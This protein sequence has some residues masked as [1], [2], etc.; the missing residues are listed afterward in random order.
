MGNFKNSVLENKSAIITGAGGFLGPRHG[1]ALS[2]AG[3]KVVLVDI[4]E[5]GLLKA[6]EKIL[7]EN[8]EGKVE[9]YKTDITSLEAV[10][11]LEK[12]LSKDNIDISILVNNAALDVKMNNKNQFT[13]KL[14]DYDLDYWNQEINV[15]LTGSFICSRVFG[16]KMATK[17]DGVIINIS[18][19]L[20]VT[21]PD[22]R[23]Y[24][25]SERYEDIELVKPI[26]YSVVKTALIGMTKYLASYWGHYG[27]RV[28][29]LLPGGIH[30][31]QE[32]HIYENIK[33]RI[34]LNRWAKIDEYED[35]IIFL[36]SDSSAFM[37]GQLLIMDGG[38]SII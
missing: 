6:R 32:K 19:D 38:R 8:R 25:Q 35:A 10:E 3:A 5:E 20:A 18:S 31:G 33:K 22:N 23:V 16:S 15:G 7:S 2:K 21:A 27:I 29:A 26:G 14:E 11:D 36:A 13:G 24:T 17:N 28:N 9:F 37:T 1:I 4:N 34:P 30:S 12:R